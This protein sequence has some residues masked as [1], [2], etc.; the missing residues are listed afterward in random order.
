MRALVGLAAF[1]LAFAQ[2]NI[3]VKNG[4]VREV[5]QASRATAAYMQIEN[6]SSQADKL[7]SASSPAAAITEIHETVD[8]KMRKIQSIDIPANSKVELK[9]GGL[10]IMLIDLKN[11]LKEGDKVD[12]TL[13]FEKA[14]EVKLQLP[15]KKSHGGGH[16]SH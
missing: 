2:Q 10:H 8:G 3:A 14:G 12:L 1:A 16:H 4:W 13:R 15:V 7:V 6:K 11:P 9:P 5:P